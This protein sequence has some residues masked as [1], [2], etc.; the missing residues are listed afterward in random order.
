MKILIL[1]LLLFS[2]S[3]FA[4]TKEFISSY[5]ISQEKRWATEQ[6]NKEDTVINHK[7]VVSITD[8]KH[9]SKLKQKSDLALELQVYPDYFDNKKVHINFIGKKS[10]FKKFI[11]FLDKNKVKP[12]APKKKLKDSKALDNG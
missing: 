5:K 12:K 3:S 2:S 8:K 1:S 6:K 9:Q 11:N 4:S 7:I 10:Q